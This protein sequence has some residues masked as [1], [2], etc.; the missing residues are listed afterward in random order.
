MVTFF[1]NDRYSPFRVLQQCFYL[2]SDDDPDAIATRTGVMAIVQFSAK[3][4]QC[5]VLL[6]ICINYCY[7]YVRIKT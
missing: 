6:F 3:Y 5:I 1:K 2:Y 7:Y 4:L